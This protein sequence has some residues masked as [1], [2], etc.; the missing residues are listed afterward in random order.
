MDSLVFENPELNNNRS[1]EQSP[2]AE[3]Q[4]AIDF[5]NMIVALLEDLSE[6]IK[7]I[8]LEDLKSVYR[9]SEDTYP[10]ES[11]FDLNAWAIAKVNM[12]IRL[13]TEGLKRQADLKSSSA[14]QLLE[15]ITELQLESPSTQETLEYLDATQSWSPSNEDFDLANQYIKKYDLNFTFSSLDDLYIEEYKPIEFELE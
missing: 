15:E 5:S 1:S 14:G 2:E 8:D 3:Q 11:N 10:K 7:E 6:D 12:F 9:Q 4:D 13:K